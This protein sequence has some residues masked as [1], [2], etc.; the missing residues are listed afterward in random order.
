MHGK[1][2]LVTGATTG[3]GRVIAQALAGMDAQVVLA[4]RNREKA[5]E[6]VRQ[7]KLETGNEA[8]NYLLADFS[9]LGQVR[10]LA[11][12]FRDRYPRLD[13]LVNNAGA[14]FMTRQATPYGVEKTLL[15]NHLAPFLL[16]NLLLDTLLGSVPAGASGGESATGCARIINVSSESHRQGTMDFDDLGFERGY[17]VHRAYGRSKLANVLFTYELARRLAGTGVTAN[18]LHPG[19]VATDIWKTNFSWFG[20]AFKWMIGLFALT[21][22]Q[23]ADNTIYLATSPEVTGISGKYFVKRKS[24]SSSPISYDEGAARKLWEISEDLAALN[25]KS[26]IP[27]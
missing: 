16:T 11:K 17:M 24:V 7:I 9:D 18:A 8:V 23:G 14:V 3:I 20:P 21:P 27:F 12:A 15:V 6:A 4:A 1:T 19:M 2:C 25:Q 22:E 13:V 5:E 26:N 10:D